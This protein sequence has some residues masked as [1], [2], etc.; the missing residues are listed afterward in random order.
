[1]PFFPLLGVIQYLA[2]KVHCLV[3]APMARI[4]IL[5]VIMT[6]MTL[7]ALAHQIAVLHLILLI[8][9]TPVMRVILLSPVMSLTRQQQVPF[10]EMV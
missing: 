10:V 8:Q 6:V 3:S 2:L 1:M 9:P 5:M 7:T 4:T